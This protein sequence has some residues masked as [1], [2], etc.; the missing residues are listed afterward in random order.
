MHDYRTK[1]RCTMQ[2]VGGGMEVQNAKGEGAF[3]EI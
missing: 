3:V 1:I 2:D